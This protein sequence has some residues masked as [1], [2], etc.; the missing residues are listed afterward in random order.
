MH[1]GASGTY[2]WES[3]DQPW[4]ARNDL[5]G[6]INST[7]G[8]KKAGFYALKALSAPIPR[9]AA[10]LTPLS[11]DSALATAVFVKPPHIVVAIVNDID[12]EKTA[13]VFVRNARV[14][15]NH[16][17]V[18]LWTANG[19]NDQVNRSICAWTEGGLFVRVRTV[20]DS[21]VVLTFNLTST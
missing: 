2:I 8:F 6:I 3:A 12:S 15:S 16:T 4:R 21:I 20:S 10:V 13:T 9:D 17:G 11:L 18:S 19:Q 1:A 5:W 14:V 7:T